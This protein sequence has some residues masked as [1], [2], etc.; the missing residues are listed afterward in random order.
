MAPEKKIWERG[1]MVGGWVQGSKENGK[2]V[3]GDI[4]KMDRT[5]VTRQKW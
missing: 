5:F 4:K 2:I 3:P 1:E